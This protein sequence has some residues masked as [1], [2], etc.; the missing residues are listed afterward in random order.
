LKP[1]DH[2]FHAALGGLGL[3]AVAAETMSARA[4]AR[5]NA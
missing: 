4:A 2:Y 3:L 5:S 1:F